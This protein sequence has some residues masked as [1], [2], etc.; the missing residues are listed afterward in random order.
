MKYTSNNSDEWELFWRERR[1]T[2]WGKLLFFIREKFLAG[3][4]VKIAKKYTSSGIVLE[5]GCGSALSSI[6][7]GKKRGDKVL[8]LDISQKALNIAQNLAKKYGVTIEA[9]QTDIYKIP[10]KDKVADLAWNV[11]T[12]EHFL[13]P[14]PI[15]K[16]MSRVGK[17]VIC[18]VPERSFVWRS[19]SKIG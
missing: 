9:Q 17:T 4:F 14:F 15:L 8:A 18:I 6:L 3:S 1:E 16:E 19:F 11:G 10:L 2:S 13:E 7:L 12:L 5:A